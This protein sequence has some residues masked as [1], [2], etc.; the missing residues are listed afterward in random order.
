MRNIFLTILI[1]LGFTLLAGYIYL[2]SY[3][4]DYN[5]NLI[6]PGLKAKVTVERNRYGV[7]T[8][9]AANDDDLYFAWGYTN[10]QDRLFQMEITRRIAQGRISEFAGESTLKKDIFLRGVGFYEIAKHHEAKL[11]PQVQ[12]FLQQYVEGINFFMKNEKLPLYMQLLGLSPE[13]WVSAD[14]VAVAMMLNWTLAYNMKHELIYYQINRKLGRRRAAEL[15]NFI[16]IKTPTIM[17]GDRPAVADT[18]STAIIREMGQLL[19]CTSA[20]NSWVSAAHY[21]WFIDLLRNE[22]P[23]SAMQ[24]QQYP[25]FNFIST[26]IELV[27]EEEGDGL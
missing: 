22:K 26:S 21:A 15:L 24:S 8:I 19:G 16:P 12:G 13:R 17:E 11:P 27:G 20:S 25:E 7:P 18:A 23:I 2:R 1:L 14:S 4:P 6:V 5:R 10:A 9:T 3:I